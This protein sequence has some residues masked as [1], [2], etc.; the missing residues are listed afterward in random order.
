MAF[1]MSN[2]EVELA[3][4]EADPFGVPDGVALIIEPKLLLPELVATG[5]GSFRGAGA[6]GLVKVPVEVS[7]GTELVVV[8]V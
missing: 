3:L 6:G 7:A 8:S 1:S 4:G 5:D 2:A